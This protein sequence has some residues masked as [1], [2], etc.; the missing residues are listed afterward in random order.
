[1]KKRWPALRNV[2]KKKLLE[3]TAKVDK[4]L[5]N[6]KTHS[7][8]KTNELFYLN[9]SNINFR[10]WEILERKYCIRVKRLNVVIQQTEIEYCCY[11]SKS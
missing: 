3:E 1:M 11:C 9:C 4:V 7:I 8:A 2:P 10:H 5:S 6:F